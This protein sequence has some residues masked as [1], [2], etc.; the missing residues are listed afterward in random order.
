MGDGDQL[1]TALQRTVE[2]RPCRGGRRRRLGTQSSS[3]PT[4]SASRYQGTMFEWCSISVSRIRSPS[5]TLARPHAWATRL[6]A[7]VTLRVKMTSRGFGAQVAR[8]PSRARPRSVAVASSE[9]VWTPRWTFALCSA[10]VAVDRLDR[11]ASG[12]WAV[13]PLSRYASGCPLTSPLEDRELGPDLLD[14]AGSRRARSPKRLPSRSAAPTRPPRP[15]RGS[16]RS[17]APRAR[18]TSSGPPSLTMRPS[19]ITCT[20][21][22]FDQV[23]DALVVG[24]DQDAHVGAGEL[25]DALGDRPQRVDVE[26]GVGL[27][28]DRELR[29]AASPA[30]GSP[31]AS[32]RRPRTRR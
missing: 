7:P 13:A 6:I 16:S 18:S 30:A 22:G 8:R 23:Q 19:N 11:P 24:D 15:P 2:G 9:S 28:E 4:S 25:V 17:R 32:S 31:C 3:A 1:R 21:S 20:K 29:L 12:F 14:R 27:V 26:A 10:P 5:P